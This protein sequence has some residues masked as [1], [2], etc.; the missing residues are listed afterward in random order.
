MQLPGIYSKPFLLRLFVHHRSKLVERLSKLLKS[1]RFIFAAAW[2]SGLT[3]IFG[4]LQ[5]PLFWFL[6]KSSQIC[7][8]VI[9]RKIWSLEPNYDDFFPDWLSKWHDMRILLIVTWQLTFFYYWIQDW[10]WIWNFCLYKLVKIER[11]TEKL[12]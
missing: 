4:A 1:P 6:P 7:C 10:N 5:L 12:I 3:E 8:N 11:R 2:N 9:W